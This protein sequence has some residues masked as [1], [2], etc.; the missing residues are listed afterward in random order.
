ME[1]VRVAA[2]LA[3]NIS[4]KSALSPLWLCC[5]PFVSLLLSLDLSAHTTGQL[6]LPITANKRGTRQGRGRESTSQAGY[7]HHLIRCVQDDI[8]GKIPCEPT[9]GAQEGE[10]RRIEKVF[11]ADPLPSPH[12]HLTDLKFEIGFPLESFF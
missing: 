6:T 9:T 12:H 2:A 5:S 11:R 8:D 10:G 4:R 3:G 7:H 1:Y